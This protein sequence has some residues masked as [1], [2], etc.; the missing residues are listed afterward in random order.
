MA[1]RYENNSE[2]NYNEGYSEAIEKAK[3][4][5]NKL[6]QVREKLKNE[7]DLLNIELE[8]LKEKN[9]GDLDA[10]ENIIGIK[11]R[12]KT[13]RKEV[14]DLEKDKFNLLVDNDWQTKQLLDFK[15]DIEN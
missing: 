10:N 11:E 3:E 6:E 15:P 1:N 14:A 9:A 8:K 13:Y 2:K 5:A 7:K 12:I 4:I